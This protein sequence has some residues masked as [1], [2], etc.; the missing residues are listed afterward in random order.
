MTND[1]EVKEHSFK[2]VTSQRRNKRK[3]EKA[4]LAFGSAEEDVDEELVIK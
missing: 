2:L 1:S 3:Q 4:A